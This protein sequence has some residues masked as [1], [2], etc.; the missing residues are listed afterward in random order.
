MAQHVLL[1]RRDARGADD[2]LVILNPTSE[3]VALITAAA[4]QRQRDALQEQRKLNAAPFRLSADEERKQR[5][6]AK[7][8]REALQD[9]MRRKYPDASAISA[10]DYITE[11]KRAR[12]NKDYSASYPTEAE[13]ARANAPVQPQGAFVELDET[14]ILKL[15]RMG[16]KEFQRILDGAWG[17]NWAANAKRLIGPRASF[18]ASEEAAKKPRDPFARQLDLDWE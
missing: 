8:S 2:N 16:E 3:A 6:T 18:R 7:P 5:M 1:A 15:C 17:S 13:M 14:N 4:E 9:R 10:L 12:R 11:Q